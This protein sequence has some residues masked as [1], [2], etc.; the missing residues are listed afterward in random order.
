MAAP[1][2]LAVQ[3]V[4]SAALRLALNGF[5]QRDAL[6]ARTQKNRFLL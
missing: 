6:G 2:R 4:L 3:R 5:R 1:P